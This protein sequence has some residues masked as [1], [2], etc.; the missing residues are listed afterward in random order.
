MEFWDRDMYLALAD[1]VVLHL[2][3]AGAK[4]TTP[5]IPFSEEEYHIQAVPVATVNETAREV[6]LLCTGQYTAKEI[7]STFL[8]QNKDTIDNEEHLK[9]GIR[10]FLQQALN[11]GIVTVHRI[12]QRSEARITGSKDFFAPQHMSIELTTNCN[13]KC[14]YCYRDAGPKAVEQLDGQEVIRILQELA[15]L[16]LRSVELTGGEP[17]LHP[18]FREIL[19]YCASSFE[20]VALLSN[21]YYIDQDMAQWLG[22][23]RDVL[24]VQTDIDGSSP[25]RHK[26]LRGSSAAFFRASEAVKLLVKEGIN[27]R[28]AMNVTKD[29][30]DDIE[31]TLILAKQLG[32]RWFAFVPVVDF[33]RAKKL[34]LSFTPEQIKYMVALSQRM[35]E[36]YGEFFTYVEP[37]L[38]LEKFRKA[39][40]NCGAGHRTAVLGPTGKV[41]P[42]P[43]LPEEVMTIGDL[44]KMS[45]AEVFSNTV[46]EYLYHLPAPNEEFCRGCEYELYC[47][48]CY[49]RGVVTQSKN[50][51]PCKWAKANHVR[52]WF[53]WQ[54]IREE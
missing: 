3:P 27:T 39:A 43:L 8:Y 4:I 2:T 13:L 16:G 28:V 19:E 29:D 48:H 47:K 11:Y 33:G 22:R 51:S 14:I 5:S 17:L 41:R 42:C 26:A 34:D 6:L 50:P 9:K 18:Q 35:R 1:N 15:S 40:S 24:I 10:V 31:N 37:E 7:I 32:A 54:L 46:V 53:L 21:G 23:Y 38:V 12:S 44:T 20:R 36:K 49:V 52:E 30:L 45:V 25:D